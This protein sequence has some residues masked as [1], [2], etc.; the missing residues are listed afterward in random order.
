M[1]M[2]PDLQ[3][4]P[5][6]ASVDQTLP[7]PQLSP[8]EYYDVATALTATLTMTVTLKGIGP[9][10]SNGINPARAD[11]DQPGPGTDLSL[12]CLYGAGGSIAICKEGVRTRLAA[13]TE[14]EIAWVADGSE[15]TVEVAMSGTGTAAQNSAASDTWTITVTRADADNATV[16]I[17]NTTKAMGW[18][19]AINVTGLIGTSMTGWVGNPNAHSTIHSDVLMA[20]PDLLINS[21]AVA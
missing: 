7:I 16:T 12:L 19:A 11:R 2:T 21:A 3:T 20:M 10:A 14:S 6:V 18:S 1:P 15:P 4:L 9:N 17:D 13:G 5:A 8:R